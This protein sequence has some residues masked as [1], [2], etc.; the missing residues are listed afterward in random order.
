MTKETEQKLLEAMQK[1]DKA[2]EKVVS[3]SGYTDE[4]KKMRLLVEVIKE[5][6]KS[7]NTL[8]AAR[9]VR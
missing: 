2:A 7:E 3:T 8:S 6:I 1:L 4:A 5:Q 9:Q